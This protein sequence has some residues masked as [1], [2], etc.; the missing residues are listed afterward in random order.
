MICVGFLVWQENGARLVCVFG[1]WAAMNGATGRGEYPVTPTRC[2]KLPTQNIGTQFW[3][4]VE[5]QAK[6]LQMYMSWNQII[7]DNRAV[8][9]VC[10]NLIRGPTK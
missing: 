2:G 4:H 3:A 10:F 8:M 1:V 5:I 7:V 6:V 9:K